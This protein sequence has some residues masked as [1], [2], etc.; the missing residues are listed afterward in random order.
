MTTSGTPGNAGAYTQ[1]VVA[2][3]APTLYYYCTQH[4][5]MGGQANTPVFASVVVELSDSVTGASGT[6]AVG[7]QAIVGSPTATGVGGTG[8]VGNESIDIL[9]WGNAGWGEDGWGE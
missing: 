9:G 1:I 7:S 8:G 3:S 5:A 2:N 6:G 4:S